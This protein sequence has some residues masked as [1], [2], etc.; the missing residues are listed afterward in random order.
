MLEKLAIFDVDYTL[1]KQET[2]IQF[3]KFMLKKKP[4]LIFHAPK[5]VISGLLYAL[6][7]FQ[8]GKAKEIFI[9]FIDGITEDKMQS[10]VKEFYD[11]N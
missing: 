11:K 7:I 4:S 1:T 2:L 6:K 9:G 8:A 10:Y 3:Y 5:I